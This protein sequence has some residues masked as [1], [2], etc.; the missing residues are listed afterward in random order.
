MSLELYLLL[1]LVSWHCQHVN[2]TEGFPEL[3]EHVNATEGFPEL[4]E[5]V[6]ATEGFPELQEHVSAHLCVD[7]SSYPSCVCLRTV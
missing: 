2:A 6:S 3:Q 1:T 7:V 5:H 4:Q